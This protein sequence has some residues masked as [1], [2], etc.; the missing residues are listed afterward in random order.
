MTLLPLKKFF[1]LLRHYLFTGLTT[2][3]LFTSISKPQIIEPRFENISVKD[4]LPENS[5]LSIVQDHLG[6]MWFGTQNG[7]V[8]YDGYKMK[9]YSYIPND[10]LSLSE[11]R[12]SA[13]YEDKSG[14]L[15]AG[16]LDGLNRFDRVT[17]KFRRFKIPTDSFMNSSS[18]VLSMYEDT[19]RNFWIGTSSGLCLLNPKTGDFKHFYFRDRIYS[20]DIYNYLSDLIHKNRRIQGIL[21]MGNSENI[22][23]SFNLKKKTPVLIVMM[24]VDGNDYGYLKDS[25]D[26]TIFTYDYNYSVHAGGSKEN[27]IQIII[28]TL[29]EGNYTLHY[30]LNYFYSYQAGYTTQSQYYQGHRRNGPLHQEY[31]GIQVF[32]I[33][34]DVAEVQKL[35]EKQLTVFNSADVFSIIEEPKNGKL[36]IGT[37]C[38]GLWELDDKKESIVRSSTIFEN[39]TANDAGS[40]R[41]FCKAKNGSI[42]IAS[43][44]GV[45]NFYPL[46]NKLKFY[47][48]SLISKYVS[49]KEFSTIVEDNYGTIWIGSTTNSM[50][51][52]D[53]KSGQI[54]RIDTSIY[55]INFR[56]WNVLSSYVDKSGVLWIG[57][58]TS[59]LEKWD[60]KKEKFEQYNIDRL[61]K[62]LNVDLN[63]NVRTIWKD[64]QGIIWLGLENKGLIS[65][66]RNNGN[67]FRYF[68]D[69]GDQNSLSNDDIYYI[70]GDKVNPEILWIATYEGLNKFNCRTKKFRHY[71]II[72]NNFPESSLNKIRFVHEDV[73]GIFWVCSQNGIYT[74]NKESGT[75]SR[76]TL[77]RSKNSSTG[78][79]L[80][81]VPITSMY[82]DKQNILWVNVIG[83]GLLCIDPSTKKWTNFRTF[84]NGD[85]YI[86][87]TAYCEDTKNNLWIGDYTSGIHLFDLKNRTSIN[88][89]QEAGLTNK[90]IISMAS[91]NKDNLWILSELELTMFNPV[92]HIHKTFSIDDNLIEVKYNEFTV[93][94]KDPAGEILIGGMNGFISFYPDSVKNDPTPPDVVIDKIS[95]FNR[96]EEKL[97]YDGFISELKEIILPYNQNDLYFE[98]VGLHYAEPLENQYQYILEGFDKKWVNAGTQRTATYTNLSPGRYI[99]RVKASNRDG[100]WNEAGTSLIIV[101]KPPF[102]ATTWAYLFYVLAFISLLYFTWKLQLKR[103]RVK[104]EYEMSKFEAQKLQE[105]DEIKSRFFT[106]ISHEFRTPLTLILGPVKQM[107]TKLNEGKMK[108]DLNIVHRNANKLLGLVNQLLDISKIESGNMKL[109]TSP[110]NIIKVV[111]VL[112]LSF[113]SY[114]ERKK[115]TLNFN[116]TE[117][118]IIVYLDKDKVEKIITNL[119]SNAFKFTPDRGRIEVSVKRDDKFV[120]IGVSDDGIGIPK[121]NMDKI[122]DRFYQVDGSHTRKQEGTGIG[123]SLTKELVE[124]HKGQIDVESEEGK[125]AAFIISLPLGGEHLHRDEIREPIED[126]DKISTTHPDSIFIED[127]KSEDSDIN[128]DKI[129]PDLINQSKKPLL[130]L[131]EDNTDVRK[132]IKDNLLEDYRIMEAVDGVDGWEKSIEHTPDLIVSDVMMPKM[133]GF[134]LCEKLKTDERT[135]HIPIIL[136]TAKAAKEDKLDGYEIGADD[137]IMKPFEPDEL[138]ARIKNLIEQ[139]KRLQNHFRMQGLSG[140]EHQKITSFDKRFLQKLLDIIKNKLPDS[141][142]SVEYLAN[143][144]AI[145]R[146]VLQRKVYSLVG[147]SPVELIRRIRLNRAAELIENKYGNISEIALEVGFSNPAYFAD[148]FKKQYGVT[149]T[150]YQRRDK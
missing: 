62:R 96:P 144:L 22:Q 132:Y 87:A 46:Q 2:I 112:V 15:W 114:A 13:L 41:S 138:K 5:V 29:R 105:M 81:H 129:N 98:Y 6:F 93:L 10:S 126:E 109:Q 145:S 111:K 19:S 14:T 79:N 90:T 94:Y 54:C 95:L 11:G 50:F 24:G 110:Q 67:Y 148:C 143:E 35:I 16:T 26:K 30:K 118:E 150:Q 99:F 74:L 42:W 28:D 107:I 3:F 141:E 44:K 49:E 134:K 37:F 72:D 8:R 113:T 45:L 101:I 86:A 52:L 39:V 4:G 20:D 23:K 103:I 36:Y 146:S 120:K 130:L 133:D 125:G 18:T 124:L 77:E 115:I 102:W 104:Q 116:S 119:L 34:N 97:D 80:N 100:V 69:P 117:D 75:F 73:N 78:K 66:D 25:R 85:Y 43:S 140:I 56:F 70:V 106:N 122:F 83:G 91:D 48:S 1:L 149:P 53:S 88:Y 142:F 9:V 64:Y 57:T 68:H 27:R 51:Y 60:R 123:L 17:E 147:E 71:K 7:L 58:W 92:T 108:D 21:N 76:I 59:G 63:V 12:V 139:R 33:S 38:Q 121:Q 31:R 61:A 65:Y 55:P 82:E 40:F 127:L 137:Y 84:P 128:A 131:V 32:D 89:S 47:T 135:S 136:L